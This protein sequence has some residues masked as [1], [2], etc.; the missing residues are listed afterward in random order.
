MRH[1]VLGVGGVGGL[2]GAAL[3]RSG[4]EVVLLMRPGSLAA[5]PGRITVQSRVLGDFTVAVPATERL[6]RDVD[7]LWVTPKATQLNAALDL[8]APA[9]VSEARVVP[10]LNGIDHVAVLRSRYAKVVPGAIRVESER[11]APGHVL[12]TS[13]FLLVEL[14]AGADLKA[15]LQ[16][17]GI[18]CALNEDEASLLWQKLVVLA[19]L[20]LATTGYGGPFGEVRNE[21]TFRGCQAEAVAVARAEGATIDGDA[22]AA[23]TD[24]VPDSMRTSMQKDVAARRAPELDAIAGPILRGGA[25]H[26]IATPAT[27]ELVRRVTAR[28]S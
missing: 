28:I 5:Y 9:N 6:E 19:P 12:Q 24:T 1:A 26:G 18:S 25:R 4:A 14:A 16:A 10:L 7:V 21:D 11:V 3:A 13:P 8:A 2:I 22:L 27:E 20:A 17:C 15:E 23:F